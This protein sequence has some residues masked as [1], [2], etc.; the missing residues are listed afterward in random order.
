MKRFVFSLG[1][2]LFVSLSFAQQERFVFIQETAKRPFY[3]RMGETS[4]SSSRGG[5]LILSSLKDSSY[6]MFVGFPRAQYPEQL[7]NVVLKGKD[8]GFELKNVDGQWQLFDLQILQLMRPIGSGDNS[9]QGPKKTDSYSELMAGV[10]NDTAVLYGTMVRQEPIRIIDTVAPQDDGSTTAGSSTPGAPVYDK[11]DIIRYSTE[12][13]M[14]GK[15]LI[16]LDRSA[17]VVD[18]IRIIIPRP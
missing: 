5:H 7:F 18:T 12:N 11:R 17:P 3:V 15:L 1:F 16:Y 6:S 8:R 9:M 4:F 10:V 13:I 14:E 2:I